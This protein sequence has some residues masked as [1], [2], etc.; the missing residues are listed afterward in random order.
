MTSETD[1]LDSLLHYCPEILFV[2]AADG[3]ILRGNE[4]LRRAFGPE[5]TN[6]RLR[7]HD[8]DRGAFERLLAQMGDAGEVSR[9]RA[10]VRLA[11]G[12]YSLFTVAVRRAPGRSEICGSLRPDEGRV[13]LEKN[14][15]LLR[16]I[17]ENL[18][19]CV[20]AID[21]N[22]VF[23]YHDG[24]GL[25]AAGLK[26]GQFVG[27]NV[28]DLYPGNEGNEPLRQAL[29][30]KVS[31]GIN[32]AHD[33]I[34]WENWHLPVRD[35]EGKVTS[36]VGVT[37]NIEES[38]STERELL[39]KIDLIQKQQEVIRSLSTP[40]IQVWDRVLTLPMIGV[41]DSMRASDVMDNLLREVVRVRARFAILDLTGVEVVDTATAAHLL[42]LIQAVKLLGADG[43]ITGLRPSI[44]QTIVSLDIDMTDITTLATL[45][46]ALKL[47]MRRL[48]DGS[49]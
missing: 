44:A 11:D 9:T 13:E 37:L 40:I 19:I 47:C 4:E 22:G 12:S 10:R 29:A 6:L 46:D 17:I 8:E 32:E 27:K 20:W 15:R 26:P 45:Q 42:S 30:G 39:A 18:N 3:T 2:A 24:K 41:V 28:F 14:S 35:E 5:G 43:I 16:I 7:I 33:G 25:A 1:Q 36:V 48:A 38:K 23:T 31:H 49:R 34:T 21:S